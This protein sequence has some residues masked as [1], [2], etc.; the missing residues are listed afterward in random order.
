MSTAPADLPA[1][2]RRL[3]NL[4]STKLGA[5]PIAATD[6]WFAPATRMLSDAPAVFLPD[7]YDA[8]GKWMDGWETRRKR[9]E[10]YDHCVVR[11]AL[12]GIIRGVDIDTSFFTGN[13]PPAASLEGC[14][15]AAGEP[16][17]DSAW[18]E[19]LPSVSLQ[20]N[21]HHYHAIDWTLLGGERPVSHVRLNIYPDGGV[22]RLR[23]WG[24]IWFD[25][26]SLSP[27]ADLEL[28]SIL[29][30]ARIV[31]YNDSHYGS[32][33]ALI[34][35]GRGVNM[36][37]G[38]ETRRRR[39]PGNDWIIVELGCAGIVER[40]EVDTAHFKGN[41]P[42]ACSIQAA[43]MHGG[44]DQS[45]VTQSM[46]WREL[47]PLQKL[48]PDAIHTYAAQLNDIGPVTH[49]RLNIHPDGGV[50]RLRVFGHRAQ[51]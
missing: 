24:E 25:A 3:P 31:A 42:D 49:V 40:I 2:A 23:V 21:A 37:D 34:A 12:A 36:G 39:E 43:C 20:G 51:G 45:I 50:S 11:L 16:D 9:V 46:F 1:Y 30:G 17:A 10:G 38:W 7:E 8:H 27:G 14:F 48:G 6:E 4:A 5:K 19:L 41:Y 28:S 18:F 13:Y 33:H 35:P 29:T 44:T 32:P 26:A 22:A 15:V 47:L